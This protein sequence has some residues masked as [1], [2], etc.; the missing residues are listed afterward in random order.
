MAYSLGKFP[1]RPSGRRGRGPSRK[2]WEGEVG[3]ATRSAGEGDRQPAEIR[4]GVLHA[5]NVRFFFS[6]TF[7]MQKS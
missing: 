3:A 2:R 6:G 1:R 4:T 5:K 7:V